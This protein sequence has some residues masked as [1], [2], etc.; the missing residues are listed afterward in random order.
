MARG[1]VPACRDNRPRSSKED[2]RK[3]TPDRLTEA[4]LLGPIYGL[5]AARVS[6]DRLLLLMIG[7][8]IGV[9]NYLPTRHNIRS[10]LDPMPRFSK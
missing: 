7:V 10:W 8:R 5:S 4:Y 6:A 1:M 2:H 3:T 9:D